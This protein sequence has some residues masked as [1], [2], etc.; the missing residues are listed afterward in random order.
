MQPLCGLQCNHISLLIVCFVFLL[1]IPTGASLIVTVHVV[2]GN[3]KAFL[4]IVLLQP[5][6]KTRVTL[7]QLVISTV[8]PWLG[9]GVCDGPAN[10]THLLLLAGQKPTSREKN[11][12]AKSETHSDF[13]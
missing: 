5:K 8:I 6:H 7:F 9:L 13:F 3:M 11:V 4:F 12:L 2:L 10:S 1:G